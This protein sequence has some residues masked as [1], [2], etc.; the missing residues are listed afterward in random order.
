[1]TFPAMPGAPTI[2]REEVVVAGIV[3]GV[4]IKPN[5]RFVV[6]VKQNPTDEY[7]VTLHTKDQNIAQFLMGQVGMAYQFKC[8]LSHY[9][10]PD[11]KP[12]TSKWINEYGP[13]GQ[14]IA[15]PQ[16]AMSTIGDA[17]PP[18]PTTSVSGPREDK[19]LKITWLAMAKGLA[20][21]CFKRLPTE[22]QTLENAVRIADYWAAA[23]MH[24]GRHG[25]PAVAAPSLDPTDVYQGDPGPQTDPDDIP[26]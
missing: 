6:K 24:R 12:V 17:P 8:G 9:N 5:G 23:A 21:E 20:V 11:G 18:Q 14:N 3:T 4:E 2:D 26:F 10:L 22:Q 16:P 25:L 19:D 7:D 1:M 15:P 13:G